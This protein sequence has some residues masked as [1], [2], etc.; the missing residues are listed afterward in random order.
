[1]IY[2]IIIALCIF[3]YAYGIM[4]KVLNHRSS[5]WAIPD[6]LKGLYDEEQYHRQQAYSRDKSQLAIIDSTVGTAI[7][8]WVF[9]SG[10]F[11]VIDGWARGI[12]DSAVLQALLFFGVMFLISWIPGQP[13]DAY[14]TFGIEQRYGLNRS[15]VKTYLLDLV[16]NILMTCLLVGGILALLVWLYG[17]MG[18]WFWLSAWVA[19]TSIT[20]FMQFF[21]SDLIVPLFNK[22]TPLPDG[23]LRTAIEAFAARVNFKLGNIYII[24]GSKRS[25]HANAYFTGYGSRKRVVLYDTLMEQLTTDEIVGVLAHEIGHY[26]HGHIVKSMVVSLLSTGLMFW[27]FGLVIDNNA[28]AEAAGCTTASF[29]VN[30]MVF[31]MLLTPF[32][33]II[34]TLTNIWSRHNERQADDFARQHGQGEHVASALMKMSA[35]S[36]SNL[37]P[38]P[39]VVFLEHSHPTLFQRVVSLSVPVAED[40]E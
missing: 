1:M 34:D 18:D 28:I 33:L 15:T 32:Y 2:N 16:K 14:A 24:D 17:L 7:S 35:K 19:V 26:K 3:E 10:G 20:L 29:H 27:L 13:L 5:K 38:H 4:C 12:T 6:V 9:A 23:E 39:V 21:Y 36:L 40:K 25:A 8:L 31:S 30:L 11:A 22:Q 37:T